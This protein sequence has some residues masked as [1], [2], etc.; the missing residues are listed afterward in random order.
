MGTRLGGP[1]CEAGWLTQLSAS[2]TAGVSC[3]PC[4]TELVA[5]LLQRVE[6]GPA[7]VP[8]CALVIVGEGRAVMEGEVL[9]EVPGVFQG[10]LPPKGGSNPVSCSILVPSLAALWLSDPSLVGML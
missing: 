6:G 7:L 9:F 1:G 4:G 2:S 8:G 3:K 10:L 5:L